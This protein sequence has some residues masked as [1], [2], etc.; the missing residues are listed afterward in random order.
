MPSG[1]IHGPLGLVL[2][3]GMPFAEGGGA[4]LCIL[5]V[6]LACPLGFEDDAVEDEKIL[7]MFVVGPAFVDFAPSAD[8]AGLVEPADAGDLADLA[9]LAESVDRL[10]PDEVLPDLEG[11]RFVLSPVL[12]PPNDGH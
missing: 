6:D 11:V 5:P 12:P 1:S 2:P 4:P 9:D 10:P 8:L 7:R 3:F